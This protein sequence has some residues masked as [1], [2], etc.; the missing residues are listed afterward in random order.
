MVQSLRFAQLPY[1]WWLMSLLCSCRSHRCSSWLWTS[2]CS[3]SDKFQQLSVPDA[4]QIRFSLCRA[5]LRVYFAA[6]L[7]HFSVSVHLDVEAQ[8]GGDAGSLT[9]NRSVTPL[10]CM[11][12]WRYRQRH[13]HNISSAPPHT[14]PHTTT[15]SAMGGLQ[16]FETQ[17]GVASHHSVLGAAASREG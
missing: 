4:P 7:Q 14:T 13:C 2:L 5:R 12:V 11:F 1:I 9:P 6:V 8:G 17:H 3:C 16:V 15:T 10:R